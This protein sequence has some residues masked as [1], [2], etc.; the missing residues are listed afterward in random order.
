MAGKNR[1]SGL[2]RQTVTLFIAGVILIGTLASFSLYKYSRRYV[3]EQITS[4]T[5][6][7]VKDL[8]AYIN[9]Y[10]AHEWLIRYWYMNWE[11]MDIEYDADYGFGT[12]TKQKCRILAD[13]QPGLQLLY[14]SREEIEALPEEDQK[15]YAEIVYS[16]LITE[17]DR[18]AENYDISY[19]F[20]VVSDEP[21][22]KQFWLFNASKYVKDKQRGDETGQ[23]FVIGKEMETTE[24]QKK[25]MRSAAAG[26]PEYAMNQDRTY[27][28]YYY[29]F[30]SFDGHDLFLGMTRNYRTIRDALVRRVLDLGML[31]LMFMS[32]LALVCLL[33]IRN[34]VLDPMRMIQ[35]NI[36]QYKDTKDSIAIAKNLEKLNTGNELELLAEDVAALVKEIDQYLEHIERITS[37]RERIETEL[38]L[39]GRI[40]ASMLPRV[41]P[42]RE[43]FE[44]YASMEPAREVG[45]DFYDFFLAD[46]NRLCLMIADVSGKGVPA[47]LFMMASR[48]TLS[49]HIR[50]GK[51]PAQILADTNEAI[52]S[53]NP[54]EMFVTVWLGILDLTT[55]IL[56]ASN[57]GHEY[58][59]L[60]REDGVYGLYRD[61]HGFVLG[62][63]TGMT[64]TEYEIE[65]KAGSALFLYTDGLAEAVDPEHSMFT[66]GRIIEVLNREPDA[67]AKTVVENM[68]KALAAYV[69]G[70]DPFDDCTMMCLKY[71]GPCGRQ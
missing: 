28:D 15:L 29:P 50:M 3:T 67:P 23:V 39:A 36:R 63:E 49:H 45:G 46:E 33:L 43:D 38:N 56:T 10:P 37:E 71:K 17:A 34:A 24:Q 68:R 42:E 51:S 54:E 58:P 20:C 6:S 57:A 55:G 8:E 18:T 70:A 48:I 26:I 22:D 7:G 27:F 47:A 19:V 69:N 61:K 4:L 9:Q 12:K 16:W 31:L 14:A 53:N 5:L 52:C 41:F 2:I 1:Q 11:E 13:R 65:M 64:Y 32:A 30:M 21:Y 40:Q 25:A 59:M 66:A 60:K 35:K 44:V 62:G